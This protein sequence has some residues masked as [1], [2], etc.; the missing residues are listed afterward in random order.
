MEMLQYLRRHYVLLMFFCGHCCFAF[1]FYKFI[2][3]RVNVVDPGVF[4]SGSEVF[5]SGLGIWAGNVTMMYAIKL[6]LCRNNKS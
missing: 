3:Y 1:S 4:W 6:Q 5:W 2:S